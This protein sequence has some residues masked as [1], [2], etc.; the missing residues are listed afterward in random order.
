V[1][2]EWYSWWL[3]VVGFGV[4]PEVEGIGDE[5]AMQ[6]AGVDEEE[7]CGGAAEAPVLGSL[8]L[9][10]VTAGDGGAEVNE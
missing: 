8:G 9:L 7:E 2:N 3:V 6:A 4:G 5:G 1:M 10:I